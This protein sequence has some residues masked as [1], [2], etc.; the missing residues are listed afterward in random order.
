[1]DYWKSNLDILKDSDTFI[2]EKLI[3]TELENGILETGSIENS[4]SRKVMVDYAKDNTPIIK[5]CENGEEWY[6]DSIYAPRQV[7]D[8]WV[9]AIGK[10][11]SS[12]VITMFGL[13]SGNLLKS[14]I[15]KSYK[16]VVIIVYE[17]SIEIFL[18]VL[19]NIDLSFLEKRVYFCVEGFNER[20]FDN[21][22]RGT[23]NYSN[24]SVCKQIYHLNYIQK[25]RDSVNS[26]LNRIKN[27]LN[28]IEVYHNTDVILADHYYNCILNNLKFIPK[29]NILEQLKN[30]VGKSIPEGLPAIIVS[31]GP[32]LN[33]N[34]LELKKAKGR[35]F[36]IAT[37]TALRGLFAADIT[38]DAF[39]IAD[40]HKAPSKFMN[41]RLHDIPVM[42]F[43]TAQYIALDFHKGKK[44]FVNDSFGYG[45]KI[46][47]DLGY[48]YKAKDSG[49]NVAST[50]FSIVKEMGFKT[51]IFV[52]QDL[53]FTNNS[54]YYEYQGNKYEIDEAQVNTYV[55]VEDING[56][57]VYTSKDYKLY[58][59]WFEDEIRRN[60][61][62]EVIDSTEGGALIHGSKL[63]DLNTAIANKCKVQFDMHKYLN[64]LPPLLDSEK[65]KEAVELIKK[66][67][68]DLKVLQDKAKKGVDLY[69]DFIKELEKESADIKLIKD[70][71]KQIGEVTEE[72]EKMKEYKVMLHKIKNVEYLTLNNLGISH[73]DVMDDANEV[74]KRGIIMMGAV[75]E[76]AEEVT[77]EFEAMVNQ[78]N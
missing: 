2:Y 49:G 65:E 26:Y 21:Y 11:E 64:D 70:L 18:T 54:K 73:D 76:I 3:N 55:K 7:A 20:E 36:I 68:V 60:Q 53:A 66:I 41:E 47:N 9:D 74:A 58:L 30:E 25:F 17:P 51:I 43:E 61:Y 12:S 56:G 34:M 50:A 6:F 38:P 19:K 42:C 77:P 29:A 24:L 67:P 63:L 69:T 45:D 37:D 71:G 14:L 62:L 16:K 8:D 32:S 10:I 15:K 33:K 31:A 22:Y 52:G 72:L 27:C 40:S 46:Y 13:G 23:V 48:E 44:I 28:I 39:V 4:I 59:D 1:M 78:I 75:R 35:A 57:E 5:L